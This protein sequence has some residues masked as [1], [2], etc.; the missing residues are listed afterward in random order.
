MSDLARDIRGTIEAWERRQTAASRIDGPLDQ[1]SRDDLVTAL[2]EAV[3][4]F[5]A[6]ASAPKS[7]K[8]FTKKGE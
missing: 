1:Q 8:R 5:T 6:D 2:L 4:A 7:A 3:T